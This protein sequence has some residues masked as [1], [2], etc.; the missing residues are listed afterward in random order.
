MKEGCCIAQIM[1]G[2][3][4]ADITAGSWSLSQGNLGTVALG[5]SVGWEPILWQRFP[6]QASSACDVVWFQVGWSVGLSPSVKRHFLGFVW[7]WVG[8]GE[9]K[10]EKRWFN[11]LYKAVFWLEGS[12]G[13]LLLPLLLRLERDQTNHEVG[14]TKFLLIA[15]W[16]QVHMASCHP[17][18]QHHFPILMAPEV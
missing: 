9:G 6:C 13:L 1:G 4:R 15:L 18:G 10:A 2:Y 8:D 7:R 16:E 5:E 14:F 11:G 3:M 17:F 12:A